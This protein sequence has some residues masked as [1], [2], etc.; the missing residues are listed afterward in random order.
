MKFDKK[1]NIWDEN[2]FSINHRNY[3]SIQA[4]ADNSNYELI[5]LDF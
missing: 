2:L 5:I 3:Y 4:T 1:H